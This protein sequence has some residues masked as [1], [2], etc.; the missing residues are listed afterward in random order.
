MIEQQYKYLRIKSSTA[1]NEYITYKLIPDW[2]DIN[3]NLYSLSIGENT[4]ATG[5]GAFAAGEYNKSTYIRNEDTIPYLL[6]V[7][8][9]T[10]ITR[11][12]AFAVGS[13]FIEIGNVRLTSAQL[14]EL[15]KLIG[16]NEDPV[17]PDDEPEIPN[18]Y[19]YITVK[20]DTTQESYLLV[21]SADGADKLLVLVKE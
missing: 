15:L 20:T 9:G 7:G 4:N 13:D 5:S 14:N 8:N 16:G 6:S 2:E 10:P 21:N 11:K 1:P 18:N 3:G 12:N 17:V 19:K